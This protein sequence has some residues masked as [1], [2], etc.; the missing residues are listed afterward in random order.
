ML[1]FDHIAI[2]AESLQAGV[3]WVEAAL[4]VKLQGGG[5]HGAMSTHNRLLSLGDLYL[6]VIAIDPE[7]PPPGRPR[8]FA[9]DAFAGRPRITNW[10]VESDDLP[11]DLAR[12][13]QGCGEIMALSRGDLRWRMAVPADGRLPYDGAHPALIQWDGPHPAPR[14]TDAGIRLNCLTICHPEGDK[15]AA[16]LPL[17]DDR[18][19]ILTGPLAFSA[20]F[21]TP[22][23]PRSLA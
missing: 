9:L 5:K 7:A 8:W 23:G 11:A 6:E 15:L 21:D 20:T 10:I 12:A 14:L 18:V 17:A 4:G 19:E 1:R 13:P 3:D 16:A 22:H 2:S